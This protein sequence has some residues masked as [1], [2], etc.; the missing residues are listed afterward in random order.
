[1]TARVIFPKTLTFR[2]EDLRRAVASLPCMC[3]GRF[4]CTQAAHTNAGKGGQIK[5]SDAAIMALCANGPGRVG[6]HA[7]VDADSDM[8]KA[9]RRAFELEMVALTYI[10]L[11]ER[12]ILVVSEEFNP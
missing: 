6:C 7:R 10:A 3:C 1:M 8:S 2:S 4:G 12:G 9:E 5:A 11:V